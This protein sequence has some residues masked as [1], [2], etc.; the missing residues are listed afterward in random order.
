MSRPRRQA[1]GA[2]LALALGAL[3]ALAS[4][5]APALA[6]GHA[7]AIRDS[8]F[9]PSSI[10]IRKGDSITWTNRGGPTTT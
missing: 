3:V 2:S 7:V 10:T 8:S 5:A 9:G 4:L 1:I 6:A